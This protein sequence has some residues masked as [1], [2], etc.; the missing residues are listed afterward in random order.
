MEFSLRLSITDL[1]NRNK[2]V[3]P[4]TV[5]AFNELFLKKR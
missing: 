1:V 5:D 2:P 4:D 3:H